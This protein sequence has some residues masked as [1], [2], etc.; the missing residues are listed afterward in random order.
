MHA[1]TV[2]HK[3]TVHSPS[4]DANFF[5]NSAGFKVWTVRMCMMQRG[6]PRA[7]VVHS[8]EAAVGLQAP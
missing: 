8:S 2:H 3:Y 1:I 4:T 6:C 5:P 7:Y